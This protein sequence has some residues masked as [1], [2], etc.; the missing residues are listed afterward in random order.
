MVVDMALGKYGSL[1]R[2]MDVVKN[3][4]LLGQRGPLPEVT[5]FASKYD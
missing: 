4:N 2:Q 5:N 1:G 3:K